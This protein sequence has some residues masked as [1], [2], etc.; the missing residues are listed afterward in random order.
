MTRQ[1]RHLTVTGLRVL[2]YL[3]IHGAGRASDIGQAI[4]ICRATVSVCTENLR[5]SKL[6]E[7][8]R[9]N[10]ATVVSITTQ[11]MEYLDVVR[12]DITPA[13]SDVKTPTI[14][15]GLKCK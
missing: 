12:R 2:A 9:R 1:V 10:N 8:T 4:G 11:G 3:D 5:I 13:P 15:E 14:R 6:V 7:K